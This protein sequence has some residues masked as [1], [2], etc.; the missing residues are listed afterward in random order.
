[1]LRKIIMWNFV[2]A[3]ITWSSWENSS[4]KEAKAYIVENKQNYAEKLFLTLGLFIVN[5]KN[6]Q[7]INLTIEPIHQSLW[8]YGTMINTIQI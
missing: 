3:F 7:F 6:S 8:F 4:F 1:M 5:F 2:F